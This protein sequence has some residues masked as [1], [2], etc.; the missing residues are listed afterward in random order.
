VINAL[1]R[2]IASALGYSESHLGLDGA[3][4]L[5]TATEVDADLSDSER[6]RDKKALY[7]KGA[8]SRWAL[9]ALE[10]DKAVFGGDD[11]GDL[12]RMPAV[13]FTPVSQADP[14]KLARTAQLMDAA[15]AA[16]RKEIVRS[17][18]PDWDEDEIGAE[19]ELIQ[20]EIGTPAPDPATFTGDDPAQAFEAADA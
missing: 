8:I 14:E 19:V 15:R 10:I 16:S 13:E 6:T 12:S 18:H 1:K 3:K 11:L 17:L 7:A 2:E 20:Q 4:G 9:A 5:R